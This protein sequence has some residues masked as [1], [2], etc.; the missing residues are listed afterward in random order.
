MAD[1]AIL[2]SLLREK[3][4]LTRALRTEIETSVKQELDAGY[5]SRLDEALQRAQKDAVK[6]AERKIGQSSRR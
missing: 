5:E 3:I 2:V 4:P 6:K 1:Q